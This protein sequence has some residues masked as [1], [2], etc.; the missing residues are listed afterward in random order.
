MA[1]VTSPCKLAHVV[2]RTA[3]YTKMFDFYKTFLGARVAFDNGELGLL[4][5]DDEHH[6]I[7][8]ANVPGTSPKEPASA[9]LWHVAFTFK[10][11]E[12]LLRAYSQRKEHGIFPTWCVNHGPTTSMYYLDPDNNQIETQIDNLD[13]EG[14]DQYMQGPSYKDNPIGVEFDPEELIQMLNNGVTAESI[15]KRIDI[16]PKDF[17]DIP[18]AIVPLANGT[19]EAEG[20]V[21][22]PAVVKASGMQNTIET[23]FKAADDPTKE[24][25]M[26]FSNCFALDGKLAARG[27]NCEGREGKYTRCI[28]ECH[29][30]GDREL[31]KFREGAWD[32]IARRKHTVHKVYVADKSSTD[33]VVLGEVIFTHK[34]G[35]SITQGFAGNFSFAKDEPLIKHYEAWLVSITAYSLRAEN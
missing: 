30:K 13:M 26:S 27:H 4:R 7:A 29:A 17:R 22:W 3:Q 21:P 20:S 24:G 5:Y 23:F 33:V 25:S 12:E 6:R 18:R 35:E 10:S 34:R 1:E 9:G 16:G 2:F 19:G 31:F 15:M 32:P 11:L 28:R 14:A 8:I